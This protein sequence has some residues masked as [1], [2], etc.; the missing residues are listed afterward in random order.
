M[1]GEMAK[2]WSS[3]LEHYYVF[4]HC[5]IRSR[6]SEE[7]HISLDFMGG[8]RSIVTFRFSAGDT[9]MRGRIYASRGMR[10]CPASQTACHQVGCRCADAGF[11]RRWEN[12]VSG[13]RPLPASSKLFLAANGSVPSDRDVRRAVRRAGVGSTWLS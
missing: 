11:Q 5:G 10:F 3:I 4:P 6:N 7:V 1:C 8:Q 13:A 2:N 12:T 9:M